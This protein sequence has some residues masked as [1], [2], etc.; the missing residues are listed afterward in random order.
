MLHSH[1]CS[2]TGADARMTPNSVQGGS[3]QRISGS[4]FRKSCLYP[5]PCHWPPSAHGQSRRWGTR[6]SV[7]RGSQRFGTALAAAEQKPEAP[8]EGFAFE[9]KALSD[10]WATLDDK[11]C[12]V[13]RDG[14]AFVG[15]VLWVTWESHGAGSQIQ[16]SKHV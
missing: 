7:L 3:P 16:P 12:H 9:A 14:K 15:K 10:L 5:P 8:L 6:D 11:E 2:H 13:V 1:A 4:T